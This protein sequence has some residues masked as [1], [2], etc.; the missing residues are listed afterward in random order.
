MQTGMGGSNCK[1][2]V[3]GGIG[4]DRLRRGE[5][6]ETGLQGGQQLVEEPRL[7][8]PGARGGGG[9]NERW[10]KNGKRKK[11]KFVTLR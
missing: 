1:Y 5:G 9:A 6:V 10:D 11:Y 3:D 8:E 4:S 7:A 2:P